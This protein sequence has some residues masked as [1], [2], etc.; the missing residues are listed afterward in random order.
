MGWVAIYEWLDYDTVNTVVLTN[1]NQAA[2]EDVT[3]SASDG[4]T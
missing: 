3:T 1:I 4:A 2:R